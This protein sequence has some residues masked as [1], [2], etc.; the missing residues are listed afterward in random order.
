MSGFCKRLAS[1]GYTI[2]PKAAQ[3]LVEFLGIELSKIDN[4]LQKLQL[5]NDQQV[6]K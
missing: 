1:N 4:E 6:V 2:T 3:M 5:I